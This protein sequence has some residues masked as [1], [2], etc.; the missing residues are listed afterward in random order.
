MSIRNKSKFLIGKCYCDG[1]TLKISNKEKINF[2]SVGKVHGTLYTF[3]VQC[4]HIW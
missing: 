1:T 2:E 3:D 4:T